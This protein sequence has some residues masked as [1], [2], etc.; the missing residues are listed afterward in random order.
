MHLLF[1]HFPFIQQ[2]IEVVYNVPGFDKMMKTDMILPLWNLQS[3]V[4]KTL[5]TLITQIL[6][7]KLW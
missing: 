5:V 6:N 3:N 7:Y 1:M 2:I 4:R